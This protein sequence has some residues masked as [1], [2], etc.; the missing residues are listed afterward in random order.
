LETSSP[1]LALAG[2]QSAEH[3]QETYHFEG[4]WVE[5]NPLAKSLL[6]ASLDQIEA[7]FK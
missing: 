6:G 4:E 2:K 3:V 7:A 5:L 1:A